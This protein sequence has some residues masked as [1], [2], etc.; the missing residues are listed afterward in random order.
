MLVSGAGLHHAVVGENVGAADRILPTMDV[1]NVGQEHGPG[2]NC[3][4]RGERRG[5]LCTK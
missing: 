4:L 1:G 2:K 3:L 5:V